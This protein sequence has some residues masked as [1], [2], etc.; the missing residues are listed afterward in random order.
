[1]AIETMQLAAGESFGI[2]TAAFR[3]QN[4]FGQPLLHARHGGHHARRIAA[5]QLDVNGS[6][7]PV[8]LNGR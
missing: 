4:D 8:W 1:M 6:A 2:D 5:P 7:P 3:A